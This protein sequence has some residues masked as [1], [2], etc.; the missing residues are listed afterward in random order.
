M[1]IFSD[2]SLQMKQ[3]VNPLQLVAQTDCV[4]PCGYLGEVGLPVVILGEVITNLT[5]IQYSNPCKAAPILWAPSGHNELPD[6]QFPFN[7]IGE[8]TMASF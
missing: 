8:S 4:S 6:F 5:H 1:Y 2:I 7:L 3:T